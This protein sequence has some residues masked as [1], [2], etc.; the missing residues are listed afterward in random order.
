MTKK[1]MLKILIP[2]V[3]VILAI[4]AFIGAKGQKSNDIN[5]DTS[6]VSKI[7]IERI[8]TLSGSIEP[9]ENEEILLPIGSKVVKLF[10]SEGNTLDSGDPIL[11][12]DVTELQN[13][14]SK[15]ELTKDQLGRDLNS[16]VN[17]TLDIEKKS[18]EN[19]VSQLQ[20][21][22]NLSKERLDDATAN[23]TNSQMLYKNGVIP[24]EEFSKTDLSLKE[25]ESQYLQNKLLLENAINKLKEYPINNSDQIKNTRNKLAQVDLDI[26]SLEKKLSDLTIKSTLPGTII[27]LTVK[28]GQTVNTTNQKI[29]IQNI[30]GYK[31]SAYALQEDATE[32]TEGQSARVIVKGIEMPYN[33]TIQKIQ[34]SALPDDKNPN[35]NPKQKVD[36]L[37]NP[38]YD[39]LVAGF[40]ADTEIITGIKKNTITVKNESIREDENKNSFVF[41]I[42]NNTLKKIVIKT[43]LSNDYYTEI[44]DGLIFGQ[45]YVT[46]P[47]Q[48]MKDGDVIK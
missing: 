27:E 3:L 34:K 10:H 8:V 43:G 41:G 36:L 24:K 31:F 14:L 23:Y 18:L 4:V 40:E 42:Q 44:L 46:N 25:A 7:D 1:R 22:V 47:S 19:S 12:L 33:A 35:Q 16:L 32:I 15:L 13:N 30:S 5:T 45:K 29:I 9:L 2:V 11:Q 17:P 21:Q 37:I 26:Q 48:E 6:T 28:E 39:N 38:P 20:I